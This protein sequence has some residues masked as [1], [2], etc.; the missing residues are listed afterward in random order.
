[1][2]YGWLF[3]LKNTLIGPFNQKSND[4]L[5]GKTTISTTLFI[6]KKNVK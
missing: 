2:S 6:V 3:N 4:H 1:M 5:I